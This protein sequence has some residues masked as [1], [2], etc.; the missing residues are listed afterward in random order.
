MLVHNHAS[1]ARPSFPQSNRS[2]TE[3]EDLSR[4]S[5]HSH[6]HNSS[7]SHNEDTDYLSKVSPASPN[8]RSSRTSSK[9]LL[10]F[11][12]LRGALRR[13]SLQARPLSP[14][15][16]AQPKAGRLVEDKFESSHVTE[17]NFEGI[18][19]TLKAVQLD[20]QPN[21]FPVTTLCFQNDL[22]YQTLLSIM[23]TA[24]QTAKP[25]CQGYGN[26]DLR[27]DMFLLS[28]SKEPS[29][30]VTQFTI[31]LA[32]AIFNN[33]DHL[34]V[35]AMPY[36]GKIAFFHDRHSSNLNPLPHIDVYCPS[37][38]N[39][40]SKQSAAARGKL[41]TVLIRFNRSKNS[42]EDINGTKFYKNPQRKGPVHPS[43][44][45]SEKF[46]KKIKSQQPHEVKPSK[47]QIS[48]TFFDSHF[49]WHEIGKPTQW[50]HDHKDWDRLGIQFLIF[51]PKVAS[52]NKYWRFVDFGDGLSDQVRKFN[53]LRA[54][55][56]K[57]QIDIQGIAKAVDGLIQLNTLSGEQ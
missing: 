22:L 29:K 4:A 1:F 6:S 24:T 41:L 52:T 11:I 47:E 38:I 2:L 16:T 17:F 57:E 25:Q 46:I 21:A 36:N 37:L 20:H 9:G 8:T 56:L 5:S 43:T 44:P 40:P 42:E 51:S 23:H 50:Q 18:T 33:T 45:F 54:L 15:T 27:K 34:K 39:R 31:G 19:G 3:S 53:Q 14:E 55:S 13:P 32:K 12:Q 26:E 48:I 28:R 49:Q 7:N 10:G 30:L 35:N